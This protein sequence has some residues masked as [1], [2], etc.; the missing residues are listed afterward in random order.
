MVHKHNFLKNFEEREKMLPSQWILERFG[1]CPGQHLADLGCG[2][3]YFTLRAA[4]MTGSYGKI[5]AVDIEKERLDFLESAATERQ[6]GAQITTY[7]AV[8][9]NIPLPD[10]CVE[11]ALIANVLH[12]LHNPGAYLH[13]AKRI[14]KQEGQLWIVEWQKKETP[15]GPPLHERKSEAEWESILSEAGFTT[16]WTEKLEPAHVLIMANKRESKDFFKGQ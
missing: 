3:G 5:E 2:Y 1:L 6:V 8:G 4:E 10:A 15:I 11:A 13:E 9:E 7:L 16:V 14:L 12:E